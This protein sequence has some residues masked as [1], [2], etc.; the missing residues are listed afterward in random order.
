M[1]FNTFFYQY[2]PYRAEVLLPHFVAADKEVEIFFSGSHH[3][4]YV[5]DLIEID[6]RAPYAKV[7]I[8]RNGMY[9]LLPEALFFEPDFLVNA[10]NSEEVKFRIDQLQKQK[11]TIQNTFKPIDNEVFSLNLYLEKKI[12][13]F[14]TAQPYFWFATFN[15]MAATSN[16]F[17][18]KMLS[19]FPFAPQI[20]GNFMIL[21]RILKVVFSAEVNFMTEYKEHGKLTL[22]V[23]KIKIFKK[24]LSTE[25]YCKQNQ[26]ASEFFKLFYEWFLPYEMNYEYQIQETET[27]FVLSKNL[28]LN[29]NTQLKK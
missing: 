21:R 26:A 12:S 10:K 22:P 4:N 24:N 8:S 6:D 16:S 19:L 11:N 2:Y 15:D 3:R 23:L 1:K 28:T 20:R 17:I 13:E 14:L 27:P 29:Y 18:Q 25:A 7:I 9:H 5:E